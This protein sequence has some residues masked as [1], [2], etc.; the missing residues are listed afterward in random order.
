MD[1]E[2]MRTHVIRAVKGT[3]IM[4]LSGLPFLF[5]TVGYV[6]LNRPAAAASGLIGFIAALVIF[7]IE[8][9][10][11][12]W[13]DENKV[14]AIRSGCVVALCVVYFLCWLIVG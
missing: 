7:S 10:S 4:L 3:L 2:N 8:E 12:E 14:L 1:Q 9:T 6:L 5:A 13:A 11:V